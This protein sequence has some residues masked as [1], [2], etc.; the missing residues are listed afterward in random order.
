VTLMGTHDTTGLLGV[1]G[2]GDFL[3]F[4]ANCTGTNIFTGSDKGTAKH[5]IKVC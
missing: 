1:I 5:P 3:L 4:S 2:E